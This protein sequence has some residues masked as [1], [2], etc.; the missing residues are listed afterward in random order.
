MCRMGGGKPGFVGVGDVVSMPF[1]D[2]R[3]TP[4]SNSAAFS[5]CGWSEFPTTHEIK[6][7]MV[8]HAE[9]RCAADGVRGAVPAYDPSDACSVHHAPALPMHHVPASFPE[10]CGLAP[11]GEYCVLDDDGMD[12]YDLDDC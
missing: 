5:A 3:E 2:A 9:W 8:Y 7:I 10:S 1:L 4:A 11:I 6:K 12:D